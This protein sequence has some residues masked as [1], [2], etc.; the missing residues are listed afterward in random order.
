MRRL[1]LFFFAQ[2]LV[3]ALLGVILLGQQM[4]QALWIGGALIAGALLMSL[5]EPKRER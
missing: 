4:T 5:V 3:G 2:P 1:R